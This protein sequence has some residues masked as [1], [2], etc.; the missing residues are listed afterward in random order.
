[1]LV[2][3]GSSKTI[4]PMVVDASS[5]TVTSADK[6]SVWKLAALAVPSAMMPPFQ[7]AEFVQLPPIALIHVPE[8]ACV[9]I[10]VRPRHKPINAIR[11][12]QRSVAERKR[13]VRH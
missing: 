4:L 2:L 12:S 11:K 10:G 7:F 3:S 6:L 9:E 5:V 13:R 1:G 8:A